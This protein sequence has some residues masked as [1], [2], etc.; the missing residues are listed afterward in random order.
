M[1]LISSTPWGD[2]ILNDVN[3][4]SQA[5]DD[6]NDAVFG[7]ATKPAWR[8]HMGI[9]ESARSIPKIA[10]AVYCGAARPGASH[11]IPA[12]SVGYREPHQNP[13]RTARKYAR[14]QGLG[15]H[16]NHPWVWSAYFNYSKSIS[17]SRR[18]ILRFLVLISA[19]SELHS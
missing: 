19:L 12:V 5:S 4:A 18:A 9:D 2:L 7:S 13:A 15:G 11:S 16:T 6:G 10:P 3:P 1:G 14:R 8:P 17:A